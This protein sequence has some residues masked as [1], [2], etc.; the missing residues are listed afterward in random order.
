MTRSPPAP[1]IP[2]VGSLADPTPSD[3]NGDTG[4]TPPAVSPQAEPGLIDTRLLLEV[5]DG[6]VRGTFS[7]SLTSSAARNLTEGPATARLAEA[8]D[9]LDDLVRELRHTVLNAHL[10][11]PRVPGQGSRHPPAAHP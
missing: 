11:S 5:L 2:A 8:L 9:E 7:V 6:A 10:P 4:P 1:M 3:G